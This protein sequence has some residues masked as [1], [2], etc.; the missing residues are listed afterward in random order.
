MTTFKDIQGRTIKLGDRVAYASYKNL[1]MTVGTV[2]KLGR[3]NVHVTPAP[4]AFNPATENF[5]P[6]ELVKLTKV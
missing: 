6:N 5:R 1:G 4:T 2:T 3:V